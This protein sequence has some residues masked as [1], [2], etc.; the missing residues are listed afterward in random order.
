MYYVY[1]C[2]VFSAVVH[3]LLTSSMPIWD[4]LSYR[5]KTEWISRTL[6]FCTGLSLLVFDFSIVTWGIMRVINLFK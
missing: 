3:C 2:V 4:R 1:L 6:G 5:T